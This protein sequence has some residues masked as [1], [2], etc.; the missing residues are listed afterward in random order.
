VEHV[1]EKLKWDGRKIFLLITLI[2]AGFA[3]NFFALRLFTGFNYLFGS[4]ATLLVVRL[5]G[6]RW[7]MVAALISSSW[8]IELFGHPYAMIW[9]CLEPL[10][11]GYLL[12][13]GSTRN[14]ILYDALYWPLLGAPLI[15]ILFLYVMK[16]P[17]LGTV[18]AMLMYWV[19]GIS[20]ALAASLLI[21]IFP[22]MDTCGL[23]GKAQTVP[24][25]IMI[26]NLMMATVV[27][28]AV[29]IMVIHGRDTDRRCMHDLF[30]WLKDSYRIAV[31]ESRLWNQQHPGQNVADHQFSSIKE[32]LRSLR[33][34]QHHTITII[35]EHNTILTSTDET[36]RPGNVF[37]PCPDGIMTGIDTSDINRC[38]PQQ[39]SPMPL[40]QRVQ[41]ATYSTS[42]KLET[43]LPW[44]VFVEAP[45]GY[46]QR[47]ILKEHINSLLGVLI[48]N[49]LTLLMSL[50]ASHRL[51]APLRRISQ[52]TTD[53]PERL[54][55][56]KIETWPS[57]MITEVDQLISNF[58]VMSE[59]LI[60][61]FREISYANETLE[62]RVEDR[63]KE[64]TRANT[65]LQKEISGHQA[66]ERQ[67][68][69][70]MNELINQLRLLQT[71]IDAIPNPIFY[72]DANGLYQGCNLAFEECWGLSREEI[73]GKT[74]DDIFP[75]ATADIFKKA[76]EQILA[77][78]EYQV[79]ETR[80]RYADGLNHAVIF[81]NA[82]FN[83]TKGNLAGLVGTIIDISSRKQAETER[84]RLMIELQRKNKELESIVYVA[85]HDLRSPLVNVQGFSRKLIKSCAEI[86]R[87]ISNLPCSDQEKEQ[88]RPILHESI[89]KSLGF[90]IGS[91]EKMDNLL[92]GLLRLSRLG[93]EAINH[94]T[95]D[96]RAIMLK[97][98]DS[99]TFQIEAAAARVEIGTLAPCVADA[100]QVNQVFSN[101]LDNA[102]KYRSP[103]RQLVIRIYSEACPEG[104]RY[105][106]E[107]N[108]IGI[109]PEHQERIWEIFHRI[110]TDAPGEGLG[111]TMARRIIDRLN[112]TITVQSEAG[113]GS[114]FM[115]TLPAA[116]ITE[117]TK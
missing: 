65:E 99:F 42:S 3:G 17:L 54:M 45:F 93:R 59:A 52:L 80:M 50:A 53:L 48:L 68:D 62:L 69:H 113:V 23:T 43:G 10:F 13:R 16:V 89:P 76:D 8:T 94:E 79:Y 77:R 51:S 39:S 63:A 61:R 103:E 107:D 26:F 34:K 116:V 30:D 31:Y 33:V 78:K 14:I 72:K 86:D 7:G 1:Q 96:I 2:A 38:M 82:T 100:V 75:V 105:V 67:L 5:F 55:R 91:I 15:W 11:V 49:L 56:E 28:P 87:I 104:I 85:S 74:V 47:I 18:A 29:F 102:I 44:T 95:L 21:S 73:V 37:A 115:V 112:G 101:L 111:L 84:D 70:M 71:L 108:G 110:S 97:I 40:W 88:L 106:I 64:L 66:T 46:Y 22:R 32:N 12:R 117:Q 36:K 83:N 4:I 90:I 20:N 9:L 6:I 60:Q 109:H 27:V 58:K 57:S 35:D 19:I 41:S 81:Y 24:I 92:N 114:R 98:E 25:H